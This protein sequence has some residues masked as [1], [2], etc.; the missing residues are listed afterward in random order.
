MASNDLDFMLPFFISIPSYPFIGL[1]LIVISLL[2]L[3]PGG[4]AWAIYKKSAGHKT[5]P[6][7]PG[8]VF[9]LSGSSAHKALANLASSLNASR[10]M[11]FSVGLTRFIISSHPNTAKEILNS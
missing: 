1:L 6:G 7:P 8:I 4:L 11:A 10:L 2:L 3:A 5:I 9:A